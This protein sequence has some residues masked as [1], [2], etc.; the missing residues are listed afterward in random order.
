MKLA[1]VSLLLAVGSVAAQV[2][3]KM[4]TASEK[5]TYIV[6][7]RDLATYVSPSAGIDLDCLPSAGS[8]DNVRRL[9]YEPGVKLALVQSDVYQSYLDLAASGNSGAEVLIRPLRIVLPLYNEEIHFVVRS[10]SPLNFVHEIKDARISAGPIGSGTALTTATLYKTMFGSPLEGATFVSNEDG[11]VKLI[12][13]KSVDVVAI[14]AGQPAKLFTDMKPEVK[15]Y[16]KLLKVDPDRAETRRALRTYFLTSVKA[17]NYP[18]LLIADVPSLS[19]KAYLTTYD[20]ITKDTRGALASFARSLC[21]NFSVLRASGHPKWQ[22]VELTMSDPGAGW[23]YFPY[24][25]AEL[26]KCGVAKRASKPSCSVEHEVLGLCG[27]K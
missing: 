17:S 1:L 15:Q 16:V 25:S 6:I 21:K 9:R 22:E 11:L 7:C 3:Y 19:V 26:A 20:Y 12:S 23:V 24:T 4:V 2:P 14:V 10:D 8:V 18:N 27:G 13:D 5:G